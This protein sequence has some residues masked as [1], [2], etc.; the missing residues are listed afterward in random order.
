MTQITD[1]GHGPRVDAGAA[2]RRSFAAAQFFSICV[3]E[4]FRSA[5]GRF[6]VIFANRVMLFLALPRM[7]GAVQE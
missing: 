1:D 5:F 6:C 4:F 7:F 3:E 2:S